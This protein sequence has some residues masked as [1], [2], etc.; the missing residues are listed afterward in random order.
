VTRAIARAI[1]RREPYEPEFRIRTP[2]GTERWILAK[3][4][5]IAAGRRRPSRMLDLALDGTAQRA[6]AAALRARSAIG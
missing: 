1:D 6:A 5:L 3:G 4:R 2:G